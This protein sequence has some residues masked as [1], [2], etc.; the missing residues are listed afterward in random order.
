LRNLFGAKYRRYAQSLKRV[1]HVIAMIK[2]GYS[3]L[4]AHPR[5]RVGL[6]LAVSLALIGL[7]VSAAQQA[8]LIASFATLRPEAIGLAAALQLLAFILNSRRWQLL[9]A[10]VGVQQRLADLTSL[11]FIGQFFS[12]FLPTGTGGDVVRAYDVAR[13]SGRPAETIMAT[14][15]ERL[16]GLGA[17]LL[18]GLV[19]TLYYLPL[20]PLQLRIWMV[21]IQIVG[22]AGI[23]LLLYPALLFGIVKRFWS[24]NKQ[25]PALQRIAGRPL[26]VRALA[27]V[28]PISELPVLRPL[29]LVLL[30]GMAITAVLM[31]IGMYYAI[32]R[33]LGLQT[34]F[35]PFCLVVPLVW[36]VRMIPVSLNGV[37]V[38]EGSFVFLIGLFDVP[39]DQALVLA[40]AVLGVMTANALLGGLLL[41][42][43]VA[44]GTWVGGRQPAPEPAVEAL[45][46]HG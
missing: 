2:R 5:L 45:S 29:R 21:I 16:L 42:L 34:G 31:G 33:S 44:R 22:A 26:V 20:V 36:I 18:I 11:Y 6:Q 30:L 9:L 40:L 1:V 37:G 8:H 23:T 12:L 27:A 35:M 43:R 3:F 32:G 17:S 41:A 28:Q 13:R 10:N 19:A 14:L 4:A 39:A 24:A 15:Q 7:L 46:E 38:S 25:R